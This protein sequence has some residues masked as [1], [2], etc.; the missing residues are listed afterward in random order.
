MKQKMCSACKKRPKQKKNR[1]LCTKCAQDGE[2]PV[3]DDDLFSP[4]DPVY[5]NRKL[6]EI[7]EEY[8]K[9]P[10]VPTRFYS[11]SD[12]SQEELRA[13]IPTPGYPVGRRDYGD[14]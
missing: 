12:M 8:H 2:R 6:N 9:N 1:F 4:T 11:A 3:F 5:L 14:G 13:L 10:P 7:I